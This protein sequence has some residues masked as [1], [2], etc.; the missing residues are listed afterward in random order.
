MNNQY[1]DCPAIMSDGRFITD[2][3]PRCLQEFQLRAKDGRPL[4]SFEY[5]QFLVN[6]A[7]DI[8]SKQRD[9][10][11]HLFTCKGCTWAT[12]PPGMRYQKCDS[13]SCT[14]TGPN[15]DGLGLERAPGQ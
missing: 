15:F 3:S 7:E 6:N 2:F 14:A 1:N 11:D 13:H 10:T 9:V 5:R 4:T 12:A 8:I